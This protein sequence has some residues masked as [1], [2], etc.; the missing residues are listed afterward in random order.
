MT[1]DIL[2]QKPKLLILK[3]HNLG[4]MEQGEKI[5]EALVDQADDVEVAAEVPIK[6]EKAEDGQSD[7]ELAANIQTRTYEALSELSIKRNPSWF[8]SEKCISGVIDYIYKQH[9]LCVLD[10]SEN[11]LQSD[12]IGQILH[13]LNESKSI[14]TLE[15]LTL[16]K[17]NW[18]SDTARFKLARLL[19]IAPRLEICSIK[20]QQGVD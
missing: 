8:K 12:M 5:V 16:E 14:M 2:F 6:H 1:R 4:N 11:L 13:N 19:S 20:F 15:R 17:C 9:N 18:S 3:L 7:G 10:L